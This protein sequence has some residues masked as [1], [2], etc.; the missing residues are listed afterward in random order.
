MENI[1]SG[2]FSNIQAKI[3]MARGLI[4]EQNFVQARKFLEELVKL[5][6]K[7]PE[8]NYLLGQIYEL[9]GDFKKAA[10]CYENLLCFELSNELKNKLAQCFVDAEEYEIAYDLYS[11]LY[12]AD[13]NDISIIEQFAH[14]ARIMDR[15]DEAV[16]AYNRILD[17]DKNNIIALTQLAEIYYDSEDKMNHY[18]VKA[19]LNY[20]EN[21]LSSSIDCFK[22][23]LNY[24]KDEDEIVGIM[25][26]LAKVLSDAG[27]YEEA[28]DQYLFILNL[29]PQNEQAQ[30]Q[31]E[32]MYKK[33][34]EK[35][36][37]EPE[38][39]SWL[40]KLF[41]FLNLI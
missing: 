10:K 19:K 5:S 25:M 24:S 39:T 12:D 11:D 13:C 27:K 33:I 29:E 2:N 41:V 21:M 9:N 7:N 18:L 36:Y 23:A 20:L 31:I 16:S 6:S 32:L 17:F 3:E 28:I 22:R 1:V 34:E 26:N 35:E 8:I 4:R 15:N 30:T 14:T 38:G 37:E 40:E